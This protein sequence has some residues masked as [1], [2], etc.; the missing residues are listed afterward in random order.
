M[1]GWFWGFFSWLSK[2][3]DGLSEKDKRN[4][5]ESIIQAF[6]ALLRAFYS[7]WKRNERKE[8]A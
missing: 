4:I 5:I 8:K 3:W 6:Q 7:D 2:L 1:F